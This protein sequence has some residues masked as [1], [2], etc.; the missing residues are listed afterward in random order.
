MTLNNNN[1]C[2]NTVTSKRMN[3][4]QRRYKLLADFGKV[5][6]YLEDIY[7][8]ETLNGYLLPQFFEYAHTIRHSIIS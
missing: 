3:I 4:T 7:N 6:S 5:Y 2:C 1:L 8:I